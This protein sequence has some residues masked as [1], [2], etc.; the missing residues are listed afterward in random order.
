MGE[1]AIIDQF[2]ESFVEIS[3]NNDDESFVNVKS[4]L[5]TE[6]QLESH[7]NDNTKQNEDTFVDN[8]NFARFEVLGYQGEKQLNFIENR[9]IAKILKY[10]STF[11]EDIKDILSNH[12]AA[13]A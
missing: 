13:K 5:S 9:V 11:S 8:K 12:R 1:F 2:S 3:C 10:F 4:K 7:K 6:N